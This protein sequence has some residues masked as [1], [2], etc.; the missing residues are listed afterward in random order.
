[1]LRQP[2]QFLA[3]LGFSNHGGEH[4]LSSDETD[5]EQ[6]HNCRHGAEYWESV[7]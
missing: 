6:G 2:E 1:M 4:L 5:E 3:R 7:D